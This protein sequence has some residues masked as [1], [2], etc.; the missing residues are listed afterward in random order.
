[1]SDEGT[2]PSS[3]FSTGGG[4]HNFENHVQASFVVLM[5]SGGM[6]PCLPAWPV[7]EIKLQGRYDGYIT[8]D[9]IVITEE[10][11]GGR[12]AKLLAQIKHSLSITESDPTFGEVIQAAWLDFQNPHIFDPKSDVIALI[13]GPLSA[14]DIESARPLMEWA[15]TS[16]SAQEFLD[17]VN[18]GKFSSDGKRSKLRAFKAQLKKANKGVEVQDEELWL[19]LKSYHIL[20]YDLDIRS[21]VTLS[22]LHSHISQFSINNIPGLWALVAKEVEYFNQN[23]G[24]I[25]LDT[26]SED[27]RKAFSERLRMETMPKSLIPPKAQPLPANYAA[28]S[29]EAEAVMFASL[30]GAWNDKTGGDKA[31]ITKLIGGHD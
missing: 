12:K 16:A 29:K 30:L 4:G 27:T 6:V 24:T 14:L 26:I 22:L 9:F 7:K 3:P 19:F 1:M 17:K 15:R 13:S 2:Q 20:G 31:A 21:G 28:G 8:D 10:R 18:L 23:A 25:T 11:N 5:L